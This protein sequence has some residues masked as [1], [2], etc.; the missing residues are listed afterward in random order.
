MTSDV[1]QID[2]DY[3]AVWDTA[4]SDHA[5]EIAQANAVDIL[6]WDEAKSDQLRRAHSLAE[7]LISSSAD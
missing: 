1:R 2:V 7:A 6:D 5:T 3:I 4:W